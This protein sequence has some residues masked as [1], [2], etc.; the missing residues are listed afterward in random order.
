MKTI[1]L[2]FLCKVS[3]VLLTKHLSTR[4]STWPKSWQYLVQLAGC[5]LLADPRL[6]QHP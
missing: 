3:F 5:L 4:L 6:N 1:Y 2:G